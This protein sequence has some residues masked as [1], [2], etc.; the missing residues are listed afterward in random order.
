[1]HRSVDLE[2]VANLY[3]ALSKGEIRILC[4]CKWEA[5]RCVSLFGPPVLI[6][7]KP[8]AAGTFRV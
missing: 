3:R 2:I 4:G 8:S 6:E 7:G 5:I 1:M